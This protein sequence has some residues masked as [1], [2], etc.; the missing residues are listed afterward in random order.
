[1]NKL[2]TQIS[3]ILVIAMAVA[4]LVSAN[5]L[6]TKSLLVGNMER[7]I[8]QIEE[9]NINLTLQISRQTSL[10]KLKAEA[11]SGGFSSIKDIAYLDLPN[12]VA[13]R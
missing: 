7:E 1:M 9:E 2:T 5:T 12:S 8:K 6:A 4:N 13:S 3:L 11:L 10:N